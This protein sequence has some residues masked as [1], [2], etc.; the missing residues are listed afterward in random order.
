MS[1]GAGSIFKRRLWSRLWY[2][3]LWWSFNFFP[4]GHVWFLHSNHCNRWLLLFGE[5]PE[6]AKMLILLICKTLPFMRLTKISWCKHCDDFWISDLQKVKVP[7][8]LIPIKLALGCTCTSASKVKED[9]GGTWVVFF[10][11]LFLLF[12]FL[13]YFGYED[14]HSW[15]VNNAIQQFKLGVK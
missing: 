5:W 6:F 2:G 3:H 7:L 13:F 9:E 4:L 12:N 15:N 11:L 8:N 1:K 14:V 10:F